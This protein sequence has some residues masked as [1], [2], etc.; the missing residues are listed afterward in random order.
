MM[1]LINGQETNLKNDIKELLIH[2]LEE[3]KPYLSNNQI[4]AYRLLNNTHRFLPLT[5]DI[6]QDNAVIHVFSYIAPETFREFERALKEIIQVNDFFYK[7]NSK[8]NLNIPVSP[9]KKIVQEEYGNRFLVNLSDYLDTGLFL[10]HRETRKWISAQSRNKKILNT[11][12]YSGSFTV[13]A[14]NAGAS[15]T[16]SVDISSVYCNWIK[17]NLALNRL[18]QEKNWVYK[19]DTLEFFQYAKKKNLEFD[20]III[21]PPTFS[22]NKG[23]SFSLQKDHPRLINS[24][25]EILSSSGFVLFSNNYREFRMLPKDL[26]PCTVTEIFNTIPP[27]FRGTQPHRCYVIKKPTLSAL[28]DAK[29][30]DHQSGQG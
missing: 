18:P 12:A 25:L 15:K 27:D 6:Y 7:N 28:S 19:M 16:C 5:A 24:A 20:I 4:S 21:D 11:F 8:T 17:E 26:S 14:A 2:N 9:P 3:I 1:T 30:Y 23:K 10:D 13:Y 22:K 29:Q